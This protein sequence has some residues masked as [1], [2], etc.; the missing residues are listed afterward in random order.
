D[1]VTGEHAGLHGALDALVDS[2]DIFLGDRA[3]NDAVDEL[4]TL[5]GVGFQLDLD[6]TVLA[7]TAGLT[8]V[9]G[10]LVGGLADGLTIGDLRRAAVG[11]DLELTR[12]TLHDDFQ[13]ELA[14]AGDDGLAGLFIG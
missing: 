2:G 13:V 12:Q 8:G 10:F 6:M 14:H 5:A 11:F 7:L 4:V 9:L 3:A 1:R